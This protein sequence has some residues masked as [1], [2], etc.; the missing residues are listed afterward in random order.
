M[1]S[2][3][4]PRQWSNAM[5]SRA[6]NGATR[7]LR[8]LAIGGAG[9]G[10]LWLVYLGLT[11]DL[12]QEESAS[13]STF[14]AIAV[15]RGDLAATVVATGMMEPFARVTVQ[16]EIPGI[17]QT[18]HVD[19][20]DRVT[21]GQALVE[22]DRLRLE[23]QAA[24]LRA[25]LALE[26]AR[27]RVDVV[28]RAEQELKKAQRD[29]ARVAELG[30]K[31]ATSRERMDDLSHLLRLAEISLRDAHAERAARLAGADRAEKS[32][33]RV[34]R[35]LEKSII[36]SPID[37]I[38]IV[39]NVEVGAAVA[40]LQNGGT[41]V[42][43]L[44]DDRLIHLLGEIDENDVADVRKGQR[45]EVRIDAFPG[46][47]FGGHVRKISAAGRTE[48]GVSSFDV[49][50][51]LEPDERIRV[52]MSADA[53]VAVRDYR[54]VLLVPN[55]AIERTPEGPRARVVDVAGAGD[56]QL[57]PIREIYSDGY[58]TAISE[59][60]SI[61]DQVLVRA[62]AATATRAAGGEESD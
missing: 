38:V 58:Q 27:A 16:S 34:E 50:I 54:D 30:G 26:E 55:A 51:E 41:V 44:A 56:P 10:F 12:R 14:K 18:I 20:G 25:A 48:G 52:G 57:R 11:W 1:T 6:R 46:E 32:L 40:D 23:D 22:L 60:L 19:D 9:V 47:V 59:G 17:V 15:E 21:R 13:E 2:T 36:R 5:A 4:V 37:G 61:G 53:H 7:A 39:R 3:S 43:T 31:G 33:R 42:A 62:P 24:E 49:E 35:D 45:A 8:V 28:G 29:Y